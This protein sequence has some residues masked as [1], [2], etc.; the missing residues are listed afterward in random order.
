[1]DSCS[2]SPSAQRQLD[3]PQRRR[4]TTTDPRIIRGTASVLC[5]AITHILLPARG[6]RAGRSSREPAS[7]AINQRGV[8]P[9]GSR[10]RPTSCHA[11]LRNSTCPDFRRSEA[12]EG[13][14]VSVCA[15][16]GVV[17]LLQR[18]RHVGTRVRAC[19]STF[20]WVLAWL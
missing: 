16:H 9:K 5:F 2:D 8:S 12:H 13:S 15:A 11:R 1:M 7:I 20:G 6:A 3:L 4:C 17:E 18:L 14:V 10:G 19:R